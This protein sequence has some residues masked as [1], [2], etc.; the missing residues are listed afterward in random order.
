MTGPMKTLLWGLYVCPF[1]EMIIA[2]FRFPKGS[3]TP[4]RGRIAELAHRRETSWCFLIYS[5]K[6]FQAHDIWMLEDFVRGS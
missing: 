4:E 2:F 3:V 1:G 5:I 6:L